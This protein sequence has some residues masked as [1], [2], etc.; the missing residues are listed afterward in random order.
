VPSQKQ[1]SGYAK[2][3]HP[4]SLKNL[5][6]PGAPPVHRAEAGNRNAVTHGGHESPHRERL[7]AKEREVFD[8]LA[9][10]AP[11]RALDGSLPRHDAAMVTLLAV[12]LC[13]LENVG[14]YLAL[15]LE[16]RQDEA[17]P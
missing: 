15:R 14:S 4:N 5:Q 1:P 10:D 13:R 9:A 16:G 6:K 17:A 12:V 3:Q 8:A 7:Q 2:G 11:V